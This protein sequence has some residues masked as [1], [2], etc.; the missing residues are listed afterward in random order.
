MMV[1]RE[2][3]E[4]KNAVAKYHLCT[5]GLMM[6]KTAFLLQSWYLA[7]KSLAGWLAEAEEVA[8]IVMYGES[9]GSGTKNTG[10]KCQVIEQM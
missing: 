2:E 3:A 1:D 4:L 10:N 6:E 9:S 5:I 7:T 8:T